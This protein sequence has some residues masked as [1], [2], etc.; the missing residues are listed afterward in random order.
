MRA[1]IA[2]FQSRER[3]LAS[4]QQ[5]RA[6][7]PNS[8]FATLS[9]SWIHLLQATG[10]GL[11]LLEVRSAEVKV[12]EGFIWETLERELAE[13]NEN[14]RQLFNDRAKRA[15]IVANRP[16]LPAQDRATLTRDREQGLSSKEKEP[17]TVQALQRQLQERERLIA[18]RD[19][20]LAVMS[21]Q[22][23]DLKRIELDS[24]DRRRPVRPSAT[25]SP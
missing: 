5:V 18:E 20:R 24:M 2:L 7:A 8:R 4:F 12:T 21:S 17:A 13:A 9:T 1:L 3:A 16:P 22:L 25:V 15:G 14:V 11:S 6:V 19:H 23:D 10:S